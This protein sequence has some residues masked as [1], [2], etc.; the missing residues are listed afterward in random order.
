MNEF[1]TKEYTTPTQLSTLIDRINLEEKDPKRHAELTLKIK[2]IQYFE[3]MDTFDEK[4]ENYLICLRYFNDD[5][6]DLMKIYGGSK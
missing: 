4:N 5:F 1:S 3:N 2:N 6:N